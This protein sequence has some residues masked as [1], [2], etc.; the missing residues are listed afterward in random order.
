[1]LEEMVRNREQ[2]LVWAKIPA[3]THCVHDRESS[4]DVARVLV[5]AVG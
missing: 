3:F 4:N 2:N 1:M 5:G